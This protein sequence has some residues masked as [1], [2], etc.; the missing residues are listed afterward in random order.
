M[1]SRKRHRPRL[2]NLPRTFEAHLMKML[3][4]A[5]GIAIRDWTSMEELYFPGQKPPRLSKLLML[6]RKAFPKTLPR[7]KPPKAVRPR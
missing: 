1:S 5:V 2:Q 6:E 7:K 4:I 3:E